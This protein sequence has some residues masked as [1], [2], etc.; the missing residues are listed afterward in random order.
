MAIKTYTEQLEMVQTAIA[1]IEEGGQAYSITGASSG[2]S[3]SLPDLPVL[4]AREERL[5]AKVARENRGQSGSRVN[6]VE[7]G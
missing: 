2:R 4:Y 5:L 7:F 3:L 6:Y 1:K